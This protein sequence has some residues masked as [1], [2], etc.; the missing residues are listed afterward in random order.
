VEERA[1]FYKEKLRDPRWQKK[2]LEIFERDNWRCAFCGDATSPLAV[3]HRWYENGKEP[4]EAS[5]EALLTLCDQCHQDEYE[6]RA[7]AEVGLVNA[8]RRTDFTAW[9]LKQVLSKGI[10]GMQMVAPSTVVAVALSELFESPERIRELVDGFLART[11]AASGMEIAT[12]D[13]I[14]KGGRIR[15]PA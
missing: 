12:V 13:E 10:A 6:M 7:E 8:L 14:S 1:R 9:D 5:N 4:W 3:H 15:G 11:L 2:R